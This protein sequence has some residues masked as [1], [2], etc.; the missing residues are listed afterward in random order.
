LKKLNSKS[1]TVTEKEEPSP[2]LSRRSP[3]LVGKENNQPGSYTPKNLIRKSVGG[4]KKRVSFGDALSPEYFDKR[5]PPIT[6]VRLGESP[7][8]TPANKHRRKSDPLRYKTIVSSAKRVSLGIGLSSTIIAEEEEH[9]TVA[10]LLQFD[11]PLKDPFED[12]P[13]TK[14]RLP[15]PMTAEL[16]QE[17]PKNE[18]AT[19]L[20]KDVKDVTL[21]KK[22]KLST[23]LRK[24]I[25]NQKVLRSRPS[26]S[27]PKNHLLVSGP[28]KLKTPL[29][30]EIEDQKTLKSIKNN[31]SLPTP[32]KDEIHMR[33]QLRSV[34]HKL[35]PSLKEEI[36]QGKALK[37]SKKKVLKTPLRKDILSKPLLRKTLKKGLK[38]PIRQE[39]R[40]GMCIVF[41][42]A[43]RSLL[44]TLFFVLV[45]K[46]YFLY[47]PKKVW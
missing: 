7:A 47:V 15:P 9:E 11:S 4:M 44:F 1:D 21:N 12:S 38:T 31:A 35:H 10:T 24:Q 27:T 29:R 18:S 46:R 41:F 6:P 25:Q 28:R 22:K 42:L 8:G 16:I 39:I 33:P 34:Y 2:E 19:N 30:K 14:M 45:L 36:K 13:N 20:Q 3:R 43:K 17:N 32:V 26:L 40:K 23:P 37:L 5:L